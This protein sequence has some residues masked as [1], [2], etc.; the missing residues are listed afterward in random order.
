MQNTIQDSQP[1]LPSFAPKIPNE[2]KM[3]MKQVDP[4]LAQR[5]LDESPHNRKRSKA[6][7]EKY[8]QQ[9]TDGRWWATGDPIKL[10]GNQLLD[11]GHRLAAIVLSGVTLPLIWVTGVHPKANRMMDQGKPRTL[12]QQLELEG[13]LAPKQ[14]A[15]AINWLIG[16]AK[17]RGL[18]VTRQFVVGDRYDL[19]AEHGQLEQVAVE[20]TQRVPG[21]GFLN[22]GM[23]ACLHYLFQQHSPEETKVFMRQVLGGENLQS[24][25][26]A[27]TYREGVTRIATDDNT[28]RTAAL[29]IKCANALITAWNKFRAK[30]QWPKFKLIDTTPEIT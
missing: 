20:Y 22:Q 9:M 7:V 16:Y 12:E 29:K 17:G 13:R 24:G 19:L 23:Y 6:T 1:E 18:G 14:L 25:D 30:E 15:Q 26:P 10:N 4:G 11:G 28:Q 3:E 21:K 5:T 27:Y 2:L 8:A